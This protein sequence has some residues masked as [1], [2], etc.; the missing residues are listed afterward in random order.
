MSSIIASQRRRRPTSS[1]PFTGRG[2]LSSSVQPHRLGQPAGRV[3]GEHHD[4]AALLGRPHR[5]RRRGR[6]LA[7]PAGAAADDDAGAPGRR[8]PSSRSS[9]GRRHRRPD[10]AAPCGAEPLGQRVEAAEVD[11]LGEQR[12]LVRRSVQRLEGASLGLLE[13]H[14]LGVLGA[15]RRAAPS[16]APSRDRARRRPRARPATSARGSRPLAAAVRSATLQQRRA[17]RVDDDPAD[18]QPGRGQLRDGVGRLLHRHLL[19]QRHEVHGGLR[20]GRAGP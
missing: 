10:H 12:Q 13:R 11:A 2:V 7:D 3:D 9:A 1:T 5:Q 14:P 19:E 15:P 18:R 20:G 8:A 16:T 4:R 6:R 17:H